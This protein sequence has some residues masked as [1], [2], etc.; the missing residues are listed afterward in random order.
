MFINYCVA[1]F[2]LPAEEDTP[3]AEIVFV[4][5]ER[6]E[7]KEVIDL[8]NKVILSQGFC[9]KC[10]YGSVKSVGRVL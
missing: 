10:R 7:A 2:C 8:Y 3:F 5:L 6:A 4:G 9:E 1:N